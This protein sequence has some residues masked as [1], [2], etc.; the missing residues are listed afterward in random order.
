MISSPRR[1]SASKLAPNSGQK[2]ACRNF[3]KADGLTEREATELIAWLHE[4]GY[5]SIEVVHE[6]TQCSVRWSKPQ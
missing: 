5:A 1:D 6:A 3:A 4:A 2:H